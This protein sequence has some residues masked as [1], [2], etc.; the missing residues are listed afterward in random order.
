VA[1]GIFFLLA[2]VMFLTRKVDW[3]RNDNLTTPGQS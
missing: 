1:F 3:Y 2:G